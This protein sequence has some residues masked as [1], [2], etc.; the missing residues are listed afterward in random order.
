MF[1][2]GLGVPVTIAEC[3]E[4]GALGAAMG[5]AIAVG[6][7]PSYETAVSSMMRP[8]STFEPDVTMRQH[9]DRRYAIWTR[10]TAA[11]EPF[12]LDLRGD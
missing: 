11:M 8:K 12:W 5:A 4:T 2:D 1:A 6:L 3:D 9:Y 10:L 7:Y